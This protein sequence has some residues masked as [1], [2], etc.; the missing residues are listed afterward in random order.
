MVESSLALRER[1]R[2]M[3]VLKFVMSLN[4]ASVRLRSAKYFVELLGFF[5][6][7]SRLLSAFFL[8]LFRRHRR[9]HS[10]TFSGLPF[11]QERAFALLFSTFF[12]YQRR[13]SIAALPGFRAR[14]ARALAAATPG[15]FRLH[16]RAHC[17]LYLLTFSRFCFRHSR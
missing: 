5:F 14:L 17:A 10:R 3:R 13:H 15:W 4:V 9:L 16:S 8:G 12:R 11:C 1:A 2:L 6:R 7:H